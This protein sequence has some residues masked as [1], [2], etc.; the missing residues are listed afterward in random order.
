MKILPEEKKTHSSPDAPTH[1]SPALF[2]FHLHNA[3]FMPRTFPENLLIPKHIVA[4]RLLSVRFIDRV[5][6]TLSLAHPPLKDFFL[7]YTHKKYYTHKRQHSVSPHTSI[8]LSSHTILSLSQAVSEIDNESTVKQWRKE[9]THQAAIDC[10]KCHSKI[11]NQ[12]RCFLVQWMNEVSEQLSLQTQTF[13]IAVN[14]LDRFLSLLRPTNSTFEVNRKTLQLLGTTCLFMAAKMEEVHCYKVAEFRRVSDNTYSK[15]EIFAC[16][17]EVCRLLDWNL[18][19]PTAF[20]WHTVFIKLICIELIQDAFEL[21]TPESMHNLITYLGLL[22]RL[23]TFTHSCNLMTNSMMFVQHLLFYPSAC[24][25]AALYVTFDSVS[26]LKPLIQKFSGYKEDTLT[27]CIRNMRT[28]KELKKQFDDTLSTNGSVVEKPRRETFSY[29]SVQTSCFRTSCLSCFIFS[30]GWV[31]PEE[32]WSIHQNEL[33]DGDFIL[34]C[35]KNDRLKL[36]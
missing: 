9:F 28:V 2:Y 10:L 4:E 25:A 15:E 8:S 11:N 36:Y 22:L 3:P 30:E 33:N 34:Y 29:P 32:L 26:D 18:R 27:R 35:F 20:Y 1:S 13:Q 19:P 16:E 31:E 14:Y 23:D 17:A 6:S 21:P 5:Q 7:H 24:A 12:M